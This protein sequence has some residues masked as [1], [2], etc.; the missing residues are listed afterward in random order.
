SG[1][2]TSYARHEGQWFHFN[3]ST[4]TPCEPETV[5]KCKAYILFYIRRQFKV[6]DYLS[7]R[8]GK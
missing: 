7:I 4:V 5:A 8:N 2:Y 6:P 1:H 3:D